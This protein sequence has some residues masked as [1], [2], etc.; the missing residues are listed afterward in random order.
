LRPDDVGAQFQREKRA[1]AKAPEVGD[2]VAFSVKFCRDT[3]QQTGRTP[4]M[5]GVLL[6]HDGCF[7][8]VRWDD[9]SAAKKARLSAQWGEDFGED[10]ETNGEMVNR[11]NLCRVGLNAEFCA[12]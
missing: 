7:A 2:R 11:S 12:C 3:L 4:A 6:S 5:R 10:A 9:W 1:V 8:R